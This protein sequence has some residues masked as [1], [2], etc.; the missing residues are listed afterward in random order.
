MSLLHPYYLIAIIYMLIL[1]FQ[2]VYVKKVEKKWLWFL[3]VYLI[4][5]A[6][7]R[8]NVGPDYG[9]YQMIYYYSDTKDY[10]SIIMKGLFMEGPQSMEL[11]WLFVLINKIL[12][13]IFNAPFYMLTL[14]IAVITIFFKIEYID[15]NTFYPFTF[16]LFLFIPGF[17]VGESGQI[18]QC[19]GTYVVYYAIRFIKEEKLWMYLLCIYLAAGI[20]NVCYLFLP[21]YWIARIPLNKFW[22]LALIIL[23]IFASPFEVYKIF[24]NFLDSIASDSMLV[25]GFNGYMDESVERLNGGFGIPEGMMMILTFF[26]FCFDT[27]MKEKFPYYEYHRNYAI[28]AI[29]FYFIFRNNSIFS[30]R[31]AGSFIIFAYILIPNAMY[32]V[33]HNKKKMI[34]SFIMALVLFYFVVFSS[35]QNIKSGRFT[36][37]LYKNY[38]L[39]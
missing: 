37:D 8:E 29:C 1:S 11:E 4:I 16:I 18:R 30:S 20:H 13:N 26:L 32:V 19:L 7:L 25:V 15:N 36:I 14:V 34:H 35:F 39:P 38:L 24:G 31:L 21:M 28:V 10:V 3:A 22:M 2:E 27:P 23:S 17:F 9:S 12:I 6:G 5:V 33:S